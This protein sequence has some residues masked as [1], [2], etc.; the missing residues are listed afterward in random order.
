MNHGT[1]QQGRHR[2]IWLG[3]LI[4]VPVVAHFLVRAP[5]EP[6][7]NGDA[8]RHVMTSVFFHDFYRDL[9]IDHPQKYAED[10]YEQYPALGLLVWPPL[11]HAVTGAV[12]LFAGLSVW[13]PRILVFLSAVIGVLLIRRMG[14]RRQLADESL[15]AGVLLA[16]L[17]M[18]FIHSRHVML[19]IPTMMLCLWSIE[20][21]DD[22]LTSDK[23]RSLYIAAVA[24]AMA[25][26]TRFDA[27]M[28]LPTL[29]LMS[30]FAGQ[31]KRL[32][33]RHIVMAALVAIVLVGPTYYVI[34]KE[35]GHLHVRQATE[36][37]SGTAGQFMAPGAW[38]FYPASVSVQAGWLVTA[39]SCF[40]FL[41]GFQAKYRSFS[42]VFVSIWLGTY[43]TFTPLAELVPRHAIYW[44]PA[45]CWFAVCGLFSA[46]VFVCRIFRTA[47][48]SSLR[49][50]VSACVTLA[51]AMMT[52]A[53]L[54]QYPTWC[55][56]GYDRAAQLA[57][58]NSSPGGTIFVDS[59]WEGNFIYQV[60]LL[61][62]E[63]S[64]TVVRGNRLL[65]DFTSVPSVDMTIHAE[66]DYEIFDAI[67]SVNPECVVL[68][69]P[70]PFGDTPMADRLRSLI[71]DH[72][73]TFPLLERC[74]I[75]STFP[76]ARPFE[77]LVFDVDQKRLASLVLELADVDQ[78]T[79]HPVDDSSLSGVALHGSPSANSR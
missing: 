36:S 27:A 63:R 5:I 78:M 70:Q 53:S 35:M 30:V 39:V 72:P 1:W 10:Y 26:L 19:E 8:N 43:F 7:F 31:W 45:I 21:F 24:A 54:A 55:V 74:P 14:A 40:G 67:S 46:S 65:Y 12:M 23:N 22:W 38:Y 33:H 51:F 66:S 17:P 56:Q 37:V 76:G 61:D 50:S 59:W 34:W 57:F 16:L 48:D 62:S 64:R 13:V 77:I 71:V 68:E 3:L 47:A 44:L 60:R 18:T 25:A 28:L 58:R 49:P 15:A 6:V 75:E 9:P 11:F 32:F 69:S 41:T 4:C 73:D 52:A 2:Q 29:L 42:L 79:D 20:R